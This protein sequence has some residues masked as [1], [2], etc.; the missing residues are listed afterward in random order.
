ME[1]HAF[2]AM[3]TEIELLSGDP[4]PPETPVGVET[5]FETVEA[6]LSRFRPNSELTLLNASAGRPFA[7]SPMLIE[8]LGL[9]LDAARASGGLFDPTVLHGVIAAGYRESGDYERGTLVAT[10]PP[11]N[12]GWQGIEITTD[13]CIVVPPGIGV[14]LGGFAKGWAVDR[15]AGLLP[16]DRPWL[17]NAGGDLLAR[18]SGPSGDGWLVGVED[19][20][21][22]GT[23]VAVLRI[24]NRAVATSSTMRRRWLSDSGAVCHHIIDPRTGRP[25]ETDLASVTVVADSATEAEVMAKRLL[26]SGLA[27]ALVISDRESVPAVLIDSL[28][29]PFFADCAGT[30]LAA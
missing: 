28:G 9:A 19:P 24:R 21:Q 1:K 10:A 5:W 15:S 6:A 27:V 18:G 11:P 3:G 16:N 13:G 4:L 12:P 30:L 17:L 29:R 7:A 23:D 8:V 20:T 26:L 22:P 14:D 25:A 2:R